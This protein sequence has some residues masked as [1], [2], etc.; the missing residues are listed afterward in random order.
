MSNDDDDTTQIRAEADRDRIVRGPRGTH[1]G[2][3]RPSELLSEGLFAEGEGAPSLDTVDSNEEKGVG[4]RVAC[5]CQDPLAAKR[6][7]AEDLRRVGA[8]FDHHHCLLGP[9]PTHRHQPLAVSTEGQRRHRPAQ[10]LHRPCAAIDVSD[11]TTDVGCVSQ[12]GD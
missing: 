12:D 8:P 7:S 6:L 3:G 10:P 9:L 1:S 11:V 2:R 5:D 4:V